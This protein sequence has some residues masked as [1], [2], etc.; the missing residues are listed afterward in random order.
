ETPEGQQ[1]I[2][3]IKRESTVTFREIAITSREVPRATPASVIAATTMLPLAGGARLHIASDL[4]ADVSIEISD[5]PGF[6]C[7]RWTAPG[8]TGA[9]EAYHVDVTG[10]SP[11]QRRYWRA[12]LRRARTSAVG[13]VRSFPVLPPAGDP[14]QVRLAIAAC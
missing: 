10:L 4:P 7:P 12:T 5:T 11:R 9:Y 3:E 1:V 6:E 14:G 2:A 13:P 8:K